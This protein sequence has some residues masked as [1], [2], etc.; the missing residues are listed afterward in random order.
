MLKKNLSTLFAPKSWL[1]I[2]FFLL[3]FAGL[4][5]SACQKTEVAT[6]QKAPVQQLKNVISTE[7]AKNWFESQFGK[8]LQIDPEKILLPTNIDKDKPTDA[9]FLNSLLQIKPLWNN[10]QTAAYRQK[11]AI[12]IVPVEPIPYLDA[13]QMQYKLVIFKNENNTVDARLQ[14]FITSGHYDTF[15]TL[16]VQNFSGALL[17]IDMKGIAQNM[18]AFENGRYTHRLYSGINDN[19][20]RSATSLRRNCSDC[21]NGKSISFWE[22]FFCLVKCIFESANLSGTTP[23]NLQVIKP[24]NENKHIFSLGYDQNPA[25]NDLILS[26]ELDNTLFQ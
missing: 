13:L 18:F 8:S 16:D 15:R 21:V 24:T 14:V 17:Q 23:S 6:V 9:N 5:F 22:E 7:A 2:G 12:L 25:L 10:A 26:Q 3:L 4:W 20:A 19:T 1:F 11:Q